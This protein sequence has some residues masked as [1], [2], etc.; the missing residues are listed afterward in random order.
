MTMC[1]MILC[2]AMYTQG[3]AWL[4]FPGSN[5]RQRTQDIKGG[6]WTVHHGISTNEYYTVM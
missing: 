2:G 4:R 6:T 1:G 3:A 5:D